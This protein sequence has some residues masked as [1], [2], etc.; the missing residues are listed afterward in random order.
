MK[1]TTLTSTFL[2]LTSNTL[3][4]HLCLSSACTLAPPDQGPACGWWQMWAP[5]NEVC[6]SGSKEMNPPNPLSL[7]E[8]LTETPQILDDICGEMVGLSWGDGAPVL[9]IVDV[10]GG[11]SW[12]IAAEDIEDQDTAVCDYSGT[13]CGNAGPVFGRWYW[14]DLPIC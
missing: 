3:A 8:W 2:A 7:E 13:D 6:G 4:G 14:P 5:G 10:E 11:M 12:S 1:T 9:D